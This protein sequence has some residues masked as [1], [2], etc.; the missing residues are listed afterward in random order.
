MCRVTP[1]TCNAG[2]LDQPAGVPAIVWVTKRE[3]SHGPTYYLGRKPKASRKTSQPTHS[4]S[5]NE[6]RVSTSGTGTSTGANNSGES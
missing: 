3:L 5:V 4:Y 1:I 2:A 6:N